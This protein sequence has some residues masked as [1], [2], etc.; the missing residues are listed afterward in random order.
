MHLFSNMST[1]ISLGIYT[2]HSFQIVFLY[3]IN[4][5]RCIKMEWVGK[6]NLLKMDMEQGSYN[7]DVCVGRAL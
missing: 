3:I 4:K 7:W 1:T 5:G 2:H 6:A